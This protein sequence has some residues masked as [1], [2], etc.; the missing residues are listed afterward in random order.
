MNRNAERRPSSVC[1]PSKV[2]FTTLREIVADY[3]AEYQARAGR[4][5]EFFRIQ[6]NFREAISRASLA[7]GPGG[8]RLS[9]QR[10]IPR[11]TLQESQARLL[12]AAKELQ[13]ATT[14][15]ELHEIVREELATLRGIGELT[16]YDTALRI[17]A[18][19]RLEP[20]V[21]FLHAGTRVGARALGLATTEH[22]HPLSDI[23][24]ALACLKAHEIEDVLCIYKE[25]LAGLSSL[26]ANLKVRG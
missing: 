6:R 14:F 24:R 22:H 5:L 19:R 4:E 7:Q 18:W 23:P 10:R 8:K 13:A 15:E 26:P 1:R 16:V 11:A 9:H 17:A 20:S 12:A 3:R 21:V 2:R 25:H